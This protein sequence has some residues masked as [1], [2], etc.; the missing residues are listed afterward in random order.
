MKIAAV[1]DD[2][3][4]ISQH[5]G[6]AAYYVVFT[7]EDGRVVSQEL[8]AKP[9]HGQ[10]GGGHASHHQED[11]RGHG[12]GPEAHGL[13]TR[14]AQPIADCQVLLAGGMGR[15]AWESLNQLGI[16]VIMTDIG[17]IQQAV[18]AYL[19]GTLKDLTQLLH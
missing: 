8:R 5:F 12:F 11:S 7:V 16:Q 13:H 1:T 6:R 2:G 10:L 19:A 9:G 3:K 14:M 17:D 4:T 15:G 18:Q